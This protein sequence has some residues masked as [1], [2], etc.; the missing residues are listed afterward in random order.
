MCLLLFQSVQDFRVF[1]G[2]WAL[3]I[4]NP[5]GQF[6]DL[7]TYYGHILGHDFSEFWAVVETVSGSYRVFWSFLA[8]S[9]PFR[10]ILK[11]FEETY[12]VFRTID[13]PNLDHWFWSPDQRQGAGSF[14]NTFQNIK[15]VLGDKS[16][17]KCPSLS[18]WER[19]GVGSFIEILFSEHVLVT[20]PSKM[21][22]FEH[23]FP[24]LLENSNFRHPRRA[25]VL[26]RSILS[27]SGS[28]HGFGAFVIVWK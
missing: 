15:C 21:S 24:E 9:E 23:K 13:C 10:L 16:I 18:V 26:L 4:L 1:I 19:Q 3:E 22:D 25:F 6:G 11:R 7:F 27:I 2:V 28:S 14:R 20:N 12:C 5:F 17:Q 8:V